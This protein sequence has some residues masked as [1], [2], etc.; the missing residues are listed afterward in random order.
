MTPA[1]LKVVLGSLLIIATRFS[2][3]YSSGKLLENFSNVVIK[4]Y[5]AGYLANLCSITGNK[6]EIKLKN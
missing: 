1:A 4:S 6:I 5:L 3:V 2:P